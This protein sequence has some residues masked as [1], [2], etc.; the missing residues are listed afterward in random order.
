M[1]FSLCYPGCVSSD[2]ITVNSTGR[3]TLR[4]G[5]FSTDM[6]L[7]ETFRQSGF[8][9]GGERPEACGVQNACFP[10]D[11]LGNAN[12]EVR[13]IQKFLTTRRKQKCTW[14]REKNR[15]FSQR[16]QVFWVPNFPACEGVRRPYPEFRPPEPENP[17]P[18]RPCALRCC[19]VTCVVPLPPA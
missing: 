10:W 11:P 15:F 9:R 4:Y 14:R 1:W 8:R 17:P 12:S 13:F 19:V 3:I 16:P 6:R 18:R 2:A 7:T 5:A